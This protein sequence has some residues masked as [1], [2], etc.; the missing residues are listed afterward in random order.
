[1]HMYVV[2][3]YLPSFPLAAASGNEAPLCVCLCVC[4]CGGG[5]GGGGGGDG[6]AAGCGLHIW[7]VRPP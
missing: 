5:G 4:V 3:M 1:M 6:Y 7:T 2:H